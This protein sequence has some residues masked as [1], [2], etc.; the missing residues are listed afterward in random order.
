MRAAQAV[1]YQQVI[2]AT[3]ILVNAVPFLGANPGQA[4]YKE[5]LKLVEY[6]LEHN[7]DSPLIDLLATRIASYEDTAAE[8]AEFNARIAAIPRELAMLR[9]LMDQYGLNQSSFRHEIGSRS[10]VS[11]IMNGQRVLTLEHMRAL[12]VRFN[13]PVS[14]FIDSEDT[15]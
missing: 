6:L 15:Q 14:A 5:A 9:T 10:L 2:H 12:S 4:D 13:I 1:K 3:E 7:D 8:F 11:M